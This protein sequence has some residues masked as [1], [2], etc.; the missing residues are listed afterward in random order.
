MHFAAMSIHVQK[1]L[2]CA[3]PYR[4][5]CGCY[6]ALSELACACPYRFKCG[7]Y[8]AL[9]VQTYADKVEVA[10][11]AEHTASSHSRSSGICPSSRGVLSRE[12]SDPTRIRLVARFTLTWRTSA[13][14]SEFRLTVEARVLLH[15]LLGMSGKRLWRKGRPAL[16]WTALKAV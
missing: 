3:C 9:S 4:F 15:A 6:F 11:A 1:E 10:L 2:A 13:P 12:L 14:A 8:F 16:S 7:C 5:K